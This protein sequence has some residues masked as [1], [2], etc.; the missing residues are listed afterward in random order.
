M[1]NRSHRAGHAKSTIGRHVCS[2]PILV[3]SLAVAAACGARDEGGWTP[4]ITADSAGVTLVT[5]FAPRHFVEA[6]SEQAELTGSWGGTADG[7]PVAE[8]TG[9]ALMSNGHVAIVDGMSRQV[10]LLQA[11]GSHRVIARQG[12]GPGEVMSTSDLQVLGNLGS[13]RRTARG[14]SPAARR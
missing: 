12:G 9:A 6:F 2:C 13:P 11:D 1:L 14:R 5:H 3:I 8:V 7:L 4:S 10:L